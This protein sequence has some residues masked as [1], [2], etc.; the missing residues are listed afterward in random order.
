MPPRAKAVT[1]EGLSAS[2]GAE[3]VLT[4]IDLAVAAGEFVSLLGPSGSGKTTLLRIIAGL[5]RPRHGSVAIGDTTVAGTSW[6]PPDRRDVGLVFQDGALFPHLS[7]A[8]N[9]AYGLARGERGSARIAELLAMVDLSDYADRSP[10]TLSG[11]QQQRVAIARALA[12]APSVLLLDEPFSALDAALRSQ[13]RSQVHAILR[14][15]GVT[16][17]FVTHDQDE[18]FVM[19]DRV[20]VLRNG[21]IEQVGTP[22][23]LYQRPVNP[24]VAGFVGE[25]NVTR[26]VA[27]EGWADTIVGAVP[28]VEEIEGSVDVLIRPEQ[29]K[30]LPG[31]NAS[32]VAV[33][34]YG[35][36][37]RYDIE[38]AGGERLLVRDDN[39]DLRDRGDAVTVSF[40]G[41]GAS[42]WPAA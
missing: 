1:V 28:L 24:W 15:V 34:Y 7:V 11:G 17:I 9:V 36:D 19:G 4:A 33:E 37:T 29:L 32:I 39:P 18:A 26:G 13:V 27:A 16:T 38:L 21:A 6:V 23:E 25:A 3:P 8:E 35:H 42:A 41:G 2:Y 30:L 20:A 14:E 12:P 5:E 10:G 22:S 31:G 40:A